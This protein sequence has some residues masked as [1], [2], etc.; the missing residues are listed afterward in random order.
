[1]F[2]LDGFEIL[3]NVTHGETSLDGKLRNS[4]ATLT[5]WPSQSEDGGEYECKMLI[6]ERFQGTNNVEDVN[7]AVTVRLNVQSKITMVEITQSIE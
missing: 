3:Q 5:I 4:S 6:D 1:M 2:F 7:S